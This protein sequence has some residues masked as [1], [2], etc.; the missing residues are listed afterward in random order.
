MTLGYAVQSV[1]EILGVVA[2]VVAMI[3]DDKIAKWEKKMLRRI[4]KRLFGVKSNV[5][6]FESIQNDGRAV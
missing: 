2:L 6:P 3:Y 4:K 1:F 5:I